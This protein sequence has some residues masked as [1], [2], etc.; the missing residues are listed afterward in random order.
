MS[1][2]QESIQA[3]PNPAAD[4]KVPT[5][6]LTHNTKASDEVT[7]VADEKIAVSKPPTESTADNK[8]DAAI[9]APEAEIP[10]AITENADK[11]KED[12]LITRSDDADVSTV[13]SENTITKVPS[14]TSLGNAGDNTKEV[15]VTEKPVD[16]A[17]DPVPPAVV[18]DE[19]TI[20]STLEDRAEEKAA[21]DEEQRV[22]AN[23]KKLTEPV[24]DSVT[25]ATA[26]T[27]GEA[28]GTEPE[29]QKGAPAPATTK[30]TEEG[31]E[32]DDAG[33]EDDEEVEIE[34]PR[35]QIYGSTVSGNRIYKKQAKELFIMLEANEIDF[36]FICI[37]A[38]EKAKSYMRR[39]ALGNMT[40]PQIHVDGEFKGLYED[41]F[42]AN[43]IDELYEWLGL[44]E[45]P[46]EY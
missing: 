44:D 11:K 17:S 41:A 15:T 27:H 1:A 30:V 38:D 20:D 36:E 12:S 19:Q 25:S 45:E 22:E 35:V 13:A 18:T 29:V 23:Q 4:E 43:E 26:E 16:H 5:T 8:I 10:E 31:E 7:S 32:K 3:H 9:P 40:I 6:V 37:A 34:K 39:K 33:D 42:N 28:Q 2:P 46:F 14:S 24:V 21:I